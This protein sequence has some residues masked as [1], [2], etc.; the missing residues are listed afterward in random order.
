MADRW[1]GLSVGRAETVLSRYIRRAE[2]VVH[3]LGEFSRSWPAAISLFFLVIVVL[4]AILAPY[5][6]PQDPIKTHLLERMTPPVF[7][8]GGTRSNLL[9]T[10]HLGRDVL[11]RTLFGA[12]T[13]LLV[14]VPANAMSIVL[15][16]VL[17]IF[18]G[19]KAGTKDTII[20]RLVDAQSAFPFLV[21]AIA[22]LAFIGGG[23]LTLV[24]F[25][26]VAGWANYAR[27]V[28]GEVLSVMTQEYITAAQ[29]IGVSPARLMYRHILPN[30]LT[31]VL[32]LASLL[33]PHLIIVE[34][35]LSFLGLGVPLPTPSWGNMLAESRG[36]F[37]HAWWLLLGPGLF[38]ALTVLSFNLIIDRIQELTNPRLRQ[39]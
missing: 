16:L 39:R 36:F 19:Y 12:R 34:A 27:L 7:A 29:A 14:A 21:L 32:V 18:S 3:A 24:L 25:L 31:P 17:G 30:V 37:E 22:V 15:G 11:S 6:S 35:S 13:S 23:I 28:R 38:M 10:D 5:I 2:T 33:L 20:M 1:V 26:G 9:G 4:V 8:E